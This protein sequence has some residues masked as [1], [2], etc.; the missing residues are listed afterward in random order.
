MVLNVAER[1]ISHAA[2]A[3]WTIFDLARII[4]V[5]AKRRRRRGCVQRLVRRV[6]RNPFASNHVFPRHV[7]TVDALLVL[8]WELILITRFAPCHP[9]PGLPESASGSPGGNVGLRVNH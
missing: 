9:P 6:L 4:T 3:T 5:Y 1:L 7:S 8:P 2:H